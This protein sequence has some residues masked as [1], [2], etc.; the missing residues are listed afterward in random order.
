MDRAVLAGEELGVW[1][2]GRLVFR[3][4]GFQL[5]AG[6]MLTLEGPNGSGK[7]TL[8]RVVAGLLT[9]AA[10]RLVWDGTAIDPADQTQ[11]IAYLGHGDA[12]KAGLTVRQALRLHQRVHGATADIPA[13]LG[14]LGI[15]G[16]ADVPVRVL[17]AGQRR[18][19]A[20]ARLLTVPKPIWLLDEPTTALD[21]A[22]V[23]AFALVLTRHLATGGR[24][25]AATHLDLGIAAGRLRLEDFSP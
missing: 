22:A 18:R 13:A 24:V 8:L 25:L 3:G 1:R 10:G 6:E 5:G 23:A 15:D 16:L 11:R 7:S 19:A 14:A 21:H 17:S 12:L 20:L 9:P 4:L 2:G